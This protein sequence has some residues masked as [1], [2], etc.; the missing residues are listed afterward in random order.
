MFK[1]TK[2]YHKY[3]DIAGVLPGNAFGFNDVGLTFSV[4]ALYPKLVMK[5]RT[6][7]YAIYVWD[8]CLIKFVVILYFMNWHKSKSIMTRFGP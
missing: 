6:R 7:E 2:I 4:N 3:C 8:L 5:K 1:L